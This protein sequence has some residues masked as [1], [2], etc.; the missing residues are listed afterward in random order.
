MSSW[1]GGRRPESR[2]ASRS[3]RLILFVKASCAQGGV[4]H[5]LSDVS[6]S[7]LH[8]RRSESMVGAANPRRAVR[9]RALASQSCPRAEPVPF[10]AS[11]RMRQPPSPSRSSEGRPAQSAAGSQPSVPLGRNLWVSCTTAAPAVGAAPSDEIFLSS[12]CAAAFCSISR[13]ARL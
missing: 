3:E 6:I 2:C 10:G 12:C 13:I 9:L 11:P 7:S 5:S 8:G 1:L 4:S